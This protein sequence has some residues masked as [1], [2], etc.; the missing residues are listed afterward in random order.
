MKLPTDR[1]R[2]MRHSAQAGPR[3]ANLRDTGLRIDD[4]TS[5]L[6]LPDGSRQPAPPLAQLGP[7]VWL[8]GNRRMIRVM[9]RE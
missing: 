7:A 9:V 3:P 5:E 8:E 4:S 1:P 6:V 2:W